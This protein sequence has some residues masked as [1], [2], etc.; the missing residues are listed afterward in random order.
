VDSIDQLVPFQLS[1]KG[2]WVY[3]VPLVSISPTAVQAVVAVHDTLLR[4]KE[5]PLVGLGV[6]W[7]DQLVPSQCSANV[8]AL[9]PPTADPTAVQAVVEVQDTALRWVV[10]ELGVVG[11]VQPVPSQRCT[12]APR[13]SP[14]TAVQAVL[15]V[16]D[17]AVSS[18]CV[19]P[20]RFGV[21]WID[22][23]LPSQR[24]ANIP[25]LPPTKACPTAVHA[26][27]E[28][29]DTATRLVVLVGLAVGSIVQLVPSQRPANV[30]LLPLP[31]AVQAVV[32]VHDTPLRRL[33]TA[34]VGFGVDWI[35]QLVPFQL[36][37]NVRLS[38]G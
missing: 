9:L 3:T 1:A 19:A 4:L 25:W 37:A 8:E 17:T 26:V 6:D 38:V 12:N 11:I 30:P 22:Q 29:H 18:D 36:S 23:L 32:D 15:E 20:L 27:V 33:F 14:P 28:V 16:H 7:I 13:E 24:S 34:L 35:D 5:L 2:M 10:V 21:N 31:T